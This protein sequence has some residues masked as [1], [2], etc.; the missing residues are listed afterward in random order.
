[1]H[2]YNI[3]DPLIAT[4]SKVSHMLLGFTDKLLV[5]VTVL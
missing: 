4:T 1:M 5:D 2:V 3:Y